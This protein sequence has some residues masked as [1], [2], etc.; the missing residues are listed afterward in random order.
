LNRQARQARQEKLK[1]NPGQ[2]N[3]SLNCLA[4]RDLIFV[5]LGVLAV[6]FEFVFSWHSL[7]LEFEDV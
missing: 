7:R 1:R 4:I 2:S 6:Q 3:F 5:S